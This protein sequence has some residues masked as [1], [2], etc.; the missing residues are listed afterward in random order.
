MIQCL[1]GTLEV[2]EDK[3]S[4]ADASKIYTMVDESNYASF[5]Q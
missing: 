5:L 3:V 2:G 4:Y 1:K